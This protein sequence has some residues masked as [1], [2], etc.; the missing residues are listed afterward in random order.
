MA[1]C[2]LLNGIV[3]QC[4]YTASGVQR[5]WLANKSDVSGITYSTTGVTTGLTFTA[6]GGTFFEIVPALDSA[7][8]Q[9]D[10]Q[11]NGSRRNFL[12]T[13]NFA[14]G[15]M[16]P[17]VLSTLED[18]GLSNLIAI[19]LTAEGDYRGLGFKGAGLRATVMT[20]TSGTQ[21]G[22]DGTLN[23]TL[24]GNAKGK[25]PYISATLMNSLGLI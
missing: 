23:V 8:F 7:T 1:N 25:A 18:M 14:V 24:A 19:V 20:E 21:A 9:D 6:T 3:G 12:Q 5:L 15:A 13:V 17:A 2:E 16:S 11:V 10:L 4:D 22:N